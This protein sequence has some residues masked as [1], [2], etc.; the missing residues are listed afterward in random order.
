MTQ[1]SDYRWVTDFTRLVEIAQRP[2][3]GLTCVPL[4]NS[5][6][7][8]VVETEAYEALREMGFPARWNFNASKAGRGYIKAHLSGYATLSV[9]RFIHPNPPK[10]FRVDFRNGESRDLRRA[11]VEIVRTRRTV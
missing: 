8:A 2:G 6:L 3:S 10:E 5:D 4:T 7:P 9:A 1:H 11:N